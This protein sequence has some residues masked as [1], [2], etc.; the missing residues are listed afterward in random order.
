MVGFL[1]ERAGFEPAV[2]VTPYDSLAN[3]W[4]K[5]LTHLSETWILLTFEESP[6]C[7]RVAIKSR[8]LG[9]DFPPHCVYLAF[10]SIVARP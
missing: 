8:S 4:F 9:L 1:A 2:R 7:H 10:S 6:S 3:C 5:P